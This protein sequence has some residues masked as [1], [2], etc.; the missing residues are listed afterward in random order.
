MQYEL[1]QHIK[2][3]EAYVKKLKHVILESFNESPLFLALSFISLSPQESYIALTVVS[4]LPIAKTAPTA[5]TANA[6]YPARIH[7][8]LDFSCELT[9]SFLPAPVFFFHLL[10][11]DPS[12]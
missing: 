6:P 1:W 10:P 8:L 3:N 4:S 11:L 2:K 9:Y 5:P 12:R 7:I